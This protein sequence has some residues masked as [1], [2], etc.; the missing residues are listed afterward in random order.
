MEV[1]CGRSEYRSLPFQVE[2]PRKGCVLTVA[3]EQRSYTL[4]IYTGSFA[5]MIYSCWY[6]RVCVCV[7][8]WVLYSTGFPQNYSN[9]SASVTCLLGLKECKTTP[10]LKKIKLYGARCLPSPLPLF[11]HFKKKYFTCISC[12]WEFCLFMWLC[13]IPARW[14]YGCRGGEQIFSDSLKLELGIDVSCWVCWEGN[15]G[16]LRKSAVFSTARVFSHP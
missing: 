11:L 16:A 7:C 2:E 8:V 6:V 1:F 14:I 9:F 12:I 13:L 5:S 10:S 4:P 15:L 3:L